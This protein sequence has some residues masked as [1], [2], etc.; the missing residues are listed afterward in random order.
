VFSSCP[1]NM[2]YYTFKSDRYMIEG[3]VCCLAC[4]VLCTSAFS[5]KIPKGNLRDGNKFIP[6]PFPCAYTA[7]FHI[8]VT[9]ESNSATM[10]GYQSVYGRHMSC[11][12][13]TS[14]FGRG[15]ES[16]DFVRADIQESGNPDSGAWFSLEKKE[17]DED[18]RLYKYCDPYDS[19]FGDAS[20][21]YKHI[22]EVFYYQEVSQV[23]WNDQD[24]TRYFAIV[25]A[26]SYAYYVDKENHV[27][28]FET[29]NKGVSYKGC[30]SYE[31]N[32][33][34]EGDFMIQSGTYGSC[35]IYPLVYESPSNESNCYISSAV[36][37][38]P[39]YP[40]TSEQSSASTTVVFTPLM[41]AVILATF[42]IFF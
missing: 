37:P 12:K 26:E 3:V 32:S 36:R 27:I 1:S 5:F 18:C 13:V 19:C 40:C 29:T 30:V 25:D 34:Y 20:Y 21:I 10:N 8:D 33:T 17:D 39:Q 9:D 42:F 24:C 16:R 35:K 28:G 11:Y 31:L 6:G 41:F 7:F 14:Y 22:N 23:K 38:E 4:V 15:M 2:L